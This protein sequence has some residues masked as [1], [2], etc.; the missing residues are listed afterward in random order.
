[1]KTRQDYE[2]AL[3]TIGEIIRAWDPYDLIAEGAPQDEFDAEIAQL[4]TQIPRIRTVDDAAQAIST[5]F[6]EAFGP[7]NFQV[8]NCREVGRILY[9]GLV[10]SGFIGSAGYSR[11]QRTGRPLRARPAAE[12]PRRWTDSGGSV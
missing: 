9:D 7:D 12:P 11:L 4:T 5:V 3:L 2:R 10:R 8:E 1:M 6:S